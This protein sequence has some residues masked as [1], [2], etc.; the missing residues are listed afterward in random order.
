MEDSTEAGRLAGMLRGPLLG[1][2]VWGLEFMGLGFMGLGFMG[3]GF[4]RT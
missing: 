2:R 1:L 4:A 3:L